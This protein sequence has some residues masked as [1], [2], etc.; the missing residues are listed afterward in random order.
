MGAMKLLAGTTASV[1]AIALLAGCASESPPS[2]TEA[3]GREPT[4]V[5][6]AP[7]PNRVEKRVRPERM[8]RAATPMGTRFESRSARTAPAKARHPR[9]GAAIQRIVKL[10]SGQDNRP[11]GAGSDDRPS[12]DT[13]KKILKRLLK[14][15][16][17]A[18]EDSS[19]TDRTPAHGNERGDILELLK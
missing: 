7:K 19:A 8:R 3:T 5:P 14:K 13:P 10:V 9:V 1:A 6:A 18:G 2:S 15:E 16:K 11:S 12:Q 4:A 17:D